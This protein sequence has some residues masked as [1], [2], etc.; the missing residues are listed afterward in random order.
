VVAELIHAGQAVRR[1]DM[2][3]KIGA[4]CDHA[5]APKSYNDNNSNNNNNNSSWQLKTKQL[6]QTILR[7]QF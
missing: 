5:H 3:D 7:L 4:F 6:V 1:T 2:T